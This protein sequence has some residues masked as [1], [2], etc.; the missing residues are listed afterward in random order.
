MVGSADDGHLLSVTGGTGN[1]TIDASAVTTAANS[2]K[3]TGGGGADVMTAGAGADTFVYSQASDSTSTGYDTISAFNFAADRFDIPGASGTITGID[4]ALTT[5]NLS[6]A[7]FDTDL[8]SA[9]DGTNN[10]L[11]AHHAILFTPNGGT[12][13]G[14]TFLV[15]DL[16]G[17]AGYQAGADIVIHLTGSIG[18][19]STGDFI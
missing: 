15:I 18:A 3:F 2:V 10:H 9:L 6:T 4:S 12:L 16:N 13:A 11:L 19:M 14:Q 1:D 5:G 8:H 7:T 17:V